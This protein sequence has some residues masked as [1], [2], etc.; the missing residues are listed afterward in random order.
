MQQT[1]PYTSSGKVESKISNAPPLLKIIDAADKKKTKG[2]RDRQNIELTSNNVPFMQL[3]TQQL[4][5]LFQ[6]DK[7]SL[8]GGKIKADLKELQQELAKLSQMNGTQNLADG[9][10]GGLF[11]AINAL[12]K[13]NNENITN[14]KLNTA[15]SGIIGQAGSQGSIS[16]LEK[17]LAELNL[18]LMNG[19]IISDKTTTKGNEVLQLLAKDEDGA[20]MDNGKIGQS[21]NAT[22]TIIAEE[23]MN[24][25]KTL[26][27]QSQSGNISDELKNMLNSSQNNAKSV[28][29]EINEAESQKNYLQFNQQQLQNA[30]SN[31]DSLNMSNMENIQKLLS[32]I[33]DNL[34]S[35]SKVIIDSGEKNSEELS[36]ISMGNA[37]DTS[38]SDK[39]NNVS[40][41]DIVSQVAKEIKESVT[42]EGG[43][44]KITLNPPSLGSVEMDVS[45][46]NNRVQVVL[47]AD[48]KDVQQTL[49]NHIDQLKGS[50]Q[51]Q[52]LTIDRCDVLMQDK[53][54]EFYRSF[55]NQLF[56]QG[57]SGQENNERNQEKD[58]EKIFAETSIRIRQPGISRI[59]SDTISLFA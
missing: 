10:N 50:L 55:G 27:E 4:T 25:L 14:E 39:I 17:I 30:A 33:I 34:K 57:R 49:N 54:D 6:S 22:D 43:R 36:A 40:P 21:K 11:S 38:K 48:N 59:N 32:E 26:L 56:Q 45:V 15:L 16:D 12:L 3:L 51:T 58:G 35:A 19:N 9:I 42:N 13:E 53:H 18:K 7:S 37:N 41:T 31:S 20:V 8:S 1:I 28:M 52:G 44:I 5:S 29:Q 24:R 2:N 23:N 47:V 46:R